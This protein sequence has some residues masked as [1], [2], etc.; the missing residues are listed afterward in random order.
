MGMK[1]I[2]GTIAVA[3]GLAGTMALLP[4]SPASASTVTVSTG[5]P[6]KVKEGSTLTL[7]GSGTSDAGGSLTYAWSPAGRFDDPT[8]PTPTITGIDDGAENLTLTVTDSLGTSKSAVAKLTTTNLKP[9]IRQILAEATPANTLS[10]E[11]TATDGGLAD[12]HTGTVNWGDGQTTNTAV[13]QSAGTAVVSGSHD[14]ASGGIYPITVTITDDNNGAA[15]WSTPLAVGCTIVGTE[16]DDVITGT[17]GDDVICSLGGNDTI[18]AGDGTDDIWAGPGD[19]KIY[20]ENGKDSMFGGPGVD[21]TSG[22]AD[23]DAC[24]ASEMRLNCRL[25]WWRVP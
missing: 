10:V 22:G 23:P 16:G 18:H 13:A 7:N 6:Y 4:A 19:D 17:P 3:V 21:F 25:A 15:T 1:R 12:T 2:L 14:Y 9:M 24:Q 20:G 11:L 8:S 5:G